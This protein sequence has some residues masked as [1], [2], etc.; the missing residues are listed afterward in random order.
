[1]GVGAEI[2]QHMFGAAQGPLGVDDPV[3]AEQHPQPGGEGVWLSKRQKSA[4]ELKL[5]SMEGAAKC[6]DELAAEDAAE[7][8]DGEK[9]GSLGRDP[10]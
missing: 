8:A 4:V 7:H 5:T 2:A 1:M 3:M 9:E 6:G 10:S